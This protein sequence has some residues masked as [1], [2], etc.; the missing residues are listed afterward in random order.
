MRTLRLMTACTCVLYLF[1]ILL[2]KRKLDGISSRLLLCSG[3]TVG[4]KTANVVYFSR[5]EKAD[6]GGARNR[7]PKK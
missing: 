4:H 3:A 1:P 6:T 5:V 2:F 7:W